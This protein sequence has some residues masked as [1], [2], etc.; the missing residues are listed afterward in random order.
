MADRTKRANNAAAMQAV[1]GMG[2]EMA[3]ISVLPLGHALRGMSAGGLAGYRQDYYDVRGK[4]S[5]PGNQACN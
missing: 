4:S 1:A 5:C 2:H 3:L